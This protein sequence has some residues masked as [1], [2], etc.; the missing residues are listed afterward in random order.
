M[1][2]DCMS[3]HVIMQPLKVCVPLAG[4]WRDQVRL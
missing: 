4:P 1:N 3:F 2:P